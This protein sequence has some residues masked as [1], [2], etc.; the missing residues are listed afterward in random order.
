MGF[1]A[2][3]YNLTIHISPSRL[4]R[5]GFHFSASSNPPR[6]L[7]LG[8]KRYLIPALGVDPSNRPRMNQIDYIC[9][10]R[11]EEAGSIDG[12]RNTTYQQ[13]HKLDVSPPPVFLFTRILIDRGENR[14]LRCTV[15]ITTYFPDSGCRSLSIGCL[16]KQ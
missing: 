7:F 1:S 11:A 9:V 10:G 14:I 16:C 6:Q 15:P 2:I 8:F 3:V 4:C 12:P 13:L 5:E